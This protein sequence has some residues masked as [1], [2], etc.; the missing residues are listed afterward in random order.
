MW[1]P[2]YTRLGER[3]CRR[4][5]LPQC[6]ALA[7]EPHHRPL[8]EGSGGAEARAGECVA[9]SAPRSPGRPG[10]RWPRRP[11]PL[12]FLNQHFQGRKNRCYRLAVRAVTRAFV[13]CTRARSLKKRNLRTVSAALSASPCPPEPAAPCSRGWPRP[14]EPSRPRSFPYAA[15][16]PG[17]DATVHVTPALR[18][19]PAFSPPGCSPP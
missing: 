10:V 4:H 15:F 12:S 17:A 7:A 16:P 1:R 5:G 9:R 14:G 13:R 2:S 8:L 6:A 11:H 18:G 3:R 19:A